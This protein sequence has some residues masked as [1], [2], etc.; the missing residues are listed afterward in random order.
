MQL[1]EYDV[2]AE[3][4]SEREA[5]ERLSDNRHT[6]TNQRTPITCK[7]LASNN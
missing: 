1:D 4:S 3:F 6:D 5:I 7:H 2:Q